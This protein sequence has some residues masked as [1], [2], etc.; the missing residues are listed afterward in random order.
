MP[1][2]FFAANPAIDLPPEVNNASKLA[3]QPCC[4]SPGA[5]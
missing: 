3:D 2:G 4:G 5:G 1:A